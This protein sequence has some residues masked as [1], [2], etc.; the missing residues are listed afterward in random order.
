M[1]KITEIDVKKFV[2]ALAIP[3]SMVMDERGSNVKLWYSSVV[4]I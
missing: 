2:I 3:S 4:Q 1:E